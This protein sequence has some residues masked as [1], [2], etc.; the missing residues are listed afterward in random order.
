MVHLAT[1]GAEMSKAASLVHQ[2][3]NM[4]ALKF[5]LDGEEMRRI[6]ELGS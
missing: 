3:Q 5:D 1:R 4:A 2:G 6:S